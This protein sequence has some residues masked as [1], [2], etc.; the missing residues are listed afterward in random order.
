MRL[1]F[2][3]P[4]MSGSPTA[5]DADLP[6][7]ET[8]PPT[9]QQPQSTEQRDLES[10]NEQRAAQSARQAR[11][12]KDATTR[13]N[14][15]AATAKADALNIKSRENS[16]HH[17]SPLLFIH[18]MLEPTRNCVARA[19]S[20]AVRRARRMSSPSFLRS[21]RR[22][23]RSCPRRCWSMSARSGDG[24]SASMAI[25]SAVSVILTPAI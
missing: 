7:N 20:R 19:R 11:A 8:A 24:R 10:L 2:Q 1:K 18:R 22:T 16:R 15:R 5:P 21:K 3:L 25:C 4:N 23:V 6:N 9:V 17:R 13:F 12:M 14:L